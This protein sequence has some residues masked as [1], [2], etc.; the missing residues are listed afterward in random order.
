MIDF[1]QWILDHIDETWSQEDIERYGDCHRYATVIAHNFSGCDGQFT[2]NYYAEKSTERP[3]F[4]LN[5][6]KIISM[7]V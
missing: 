5:E 1:S 3:K 7:H 2:L 6:A 4:A